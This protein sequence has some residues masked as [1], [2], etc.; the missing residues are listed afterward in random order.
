MIHI[1]HMDLISHWKQN[2]VWVDRNIAMTTMTDRDT[3]LRGV[4][5]C[6]RYDRPMRNLG[7]TPPTDYVGTNTRI[8][9]CRSK[10]N[11]DLSADRDTVYPRR[12]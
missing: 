7:K 8:N 12:Q 6:E 2:D 9:Y 4:L 11:Y 1:C 10:E 3:N 5:S